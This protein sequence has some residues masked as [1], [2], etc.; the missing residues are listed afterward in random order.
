MY[1][2]WAEKLVRD[3][4]KKTCDAAECPDYEAKF[5][6]LLAEL[7]TR[8]PD[9]DRRAEALWRLAFRALRKKT[10]TAK[11][12]LTVALE[13][14]PRREVGWDQGRSDACTG[15]VAWLSCP[16]SN[17]GARAISAD[18]AKLSAELLRALSLNRL[19]AGFAPSLKRC[20]ASYTAIRTMN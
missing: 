11:N 8:F 7:P 12:W 5:T 13:K 2:I 16:R 3:G 19:R 1:L 15:W 20:C 18:G 14:V 6:A 4:A 9:G 10:S 17:R